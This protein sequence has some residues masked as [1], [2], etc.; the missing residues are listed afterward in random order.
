MKEIA[1]ILREPDVTIAIVGANNNP[2]KYGNVIYRDLKRKGYRL[3]PVNP[4]S[5]EIEGDKAYANL[6]HLPQKPTIVN[7]VTPPA[8]TRKVLEDCLK[9]GLHNVWLQPGSESPEVMTFIQEKQFNYLANA[10]IMVE[11][12]RGH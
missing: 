2:A 8:V 7:F 1:E 4:S 6:A 12:R 9:L 3:F 11:T 10:C 5:P